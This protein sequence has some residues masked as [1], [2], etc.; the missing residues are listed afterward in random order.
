[1]EAYYPVF[2]TIHLFAAV[3]FAGAVFFE[4]LI[5]EGIRKQFPAEFM[6]ALEISIGSRARK[7]MPWVLLMLYGGGLGMIW[8]RYLPMLEHPLQ[9][10]FASL[11][12][13]KI[14]LAISVLCHFFTAMFLLI[15][16]RMKSAYFKIIHLSVF[17]HMI[18]IIF[19][20]KAIFYWAW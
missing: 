8:G 9:T 15:S 11:L 10:G 2:L 6:N 12:L 14:I 16:K 5:L 1:M 20:A 3:I 4:V 17:T 18:L 7:I 13:L 19:L